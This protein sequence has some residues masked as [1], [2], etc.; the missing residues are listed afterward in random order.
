MK[1]LDLVC[2]KEM[3]TKSR[4]RLKQYCFT[5]DDKTFD[6]LGWNMRK[7]GSGTSFRMSLWGCLIRDLV[8]AQL[9]RAQFLHLMTGTCAQ[10]AMEERETIVGEIIDTDVR[11]EYHYYRCRNASRAW[12]VFWVETQ[13]GK[14]GWCEGSK[15]PSWAAHW[16]LLSKRVW[17]PL[18]CLHKR[19]V[20]RIP[21]LLW[22]SPES[23]HLRKHD[24][25][26][27]QTILCIQRQNTTI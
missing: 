18:W 9:C 20:R 13:G 5:V 12:C 6:H 10:V 1:I 19:M 25:I 23:R 21:V 22:P 16:F 7:L 14:K 17:S 2:L 8:W 24:C 15:R 27:H 11:V 4:R 3:V 26:L